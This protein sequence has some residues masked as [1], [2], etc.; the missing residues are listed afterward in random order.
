LAQVSGAFNAVFIEGEAC[1]SMMLYGRGAGGEPTASAV[2]GDVIDAAR[3]L[4][5]HSPAPAPIRSNPVEVIAIAELRSAFYLS[6]DVF[7]RPGV[8]A[9]VAKLFGEHRI[10][11]RSME[12]Q[13]LG[14]EARLV[15]VTHEAS[16]ADMAATIAALRSLEVVQA[17]GGVLRVIVS[18]EE[19]EK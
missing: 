9:T 19:V 15:F 8:L 1:G 18:D 16:E 17:V 7:D 13:G 6:I 11:I 5:S 14:D 12:Q 3:H 4:Q 10:S 2:L